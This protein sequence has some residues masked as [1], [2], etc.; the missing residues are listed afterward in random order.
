MVRWT[1]VDAHE[2]ARRRL[3]ADRTALR[4]LT[5]AVAGVA[6]AATALFAGLASA[7]GSH[8]SSNPGVNDGS[9][10]SNGL[11]ADS[12]PG[13]NDAP[14]FSSGAPDSVSGGS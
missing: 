10:F 9:G 11:G 3:A 12:F 14:S 6:A 2:Q 13:G 5:L 4:R 1:P 7:T 8:S